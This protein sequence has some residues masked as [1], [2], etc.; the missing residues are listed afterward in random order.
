MQN[1]KYSASYV[2]T[3]EQVKCELLIVGGKGIMNFKELLFFE[4]VAGSEN[5][6]RSE[7]FDMMLSKL[8]SLEMES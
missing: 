3:G 7:A 4:A 8:V 1:L 6:A 2:K 5:L